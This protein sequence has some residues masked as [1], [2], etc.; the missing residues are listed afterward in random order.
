MVA[1]CLKTGLVG[2]KLR[3]EK[4]LDRIIIVARIKLRIWNCPY[5]LR[6]WIPAAATD[7]RLPTLAVT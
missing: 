5:E 2:T 7:L 3:I 4:V 1:V 6:H